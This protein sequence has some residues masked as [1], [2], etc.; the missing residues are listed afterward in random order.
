MHDYF[1]NSSNHFNVFD[2]NLQNDLNNH[3]QDFLMHT[4]Q[5]K[6]S[7][8][9]DKQGILRTLNK[10]NIQ[11]IR[12]KYIDFTSNDYLGFNQNANLKSWLQQQAMQAI[13]NQF[14][15]LGATGARLLSGHHAIFEELELSIAQSKGHEQA[16]LFNNGF[17]AN[18]QVL[19]CLL[20]KEHAVFCDK[21]NHASLHQ[22][23]QIAG[24][25]QIRYE[26]L[27]LNH[28]EY[29]LK[30]HGNSYE[31]SQQV[32]W[33]ITESV[34]GMDGDIVNLENL[35]KLAKQYDCY[36]YIDEAHAT[37]LYGHLG[38]G[39]SANLDKSLDTSKLITMGTFGKAIGLAGAYIT[40]NNTIKHYLM[41]FCAGWIYSTANSPLLAYLVKQVWHLLPSLSMLKEHIYQLQIYL[42]HA[43]DLY[44]KNT[45]FNCH[46]HSHIVVIK[47]ENADY[48]KQLHQHLQACGIY[49]SN[50]Q[51]PTVAKAC[52]R[53]AVCGFHTLNQIQ[54]VEQAFKSFQPI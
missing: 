6:L 21:L 33:I 23:C 15:D 16:L 47:H 20:S 28:L 4:L 5:Q 40:C 52:L 24:V 12:L 26:H 43:I 1:L 27:D 51:P 32:R 34:F 30:S 41:N 9:L 2:T 53:M 13:A 44:L 8:K 46:S 49:A 18:S 35:L 29:R 19:A 36:V 48:I 25:K 45:G 3:S 39:L 17:Q 10:P 7:Q 50:I 54:K 11:T 22:A 14:V 37:G 42:E 38:Y 31:N